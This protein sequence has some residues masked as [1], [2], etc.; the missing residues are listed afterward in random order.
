MHAVHASG[1]GKPEA[2]PLWERV[3]AVFVNLVTKPPPEPNAKRTIKS[4]WIPVMMV[5]WPFLFW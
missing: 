2:P 1:S 4:S 5:A 3:K